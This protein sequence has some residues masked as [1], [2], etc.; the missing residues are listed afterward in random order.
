MCEI[1]KEQEDFFM[2]SRL[3]NPRKLE[4]EVER[5]FGRRKERSKINMK[6]NELPDKE[7]RIFFFSLGKEKKL[8]FVL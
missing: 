5:L 7:E 6:L 1:V 4:L 8:I 2:W 3:K